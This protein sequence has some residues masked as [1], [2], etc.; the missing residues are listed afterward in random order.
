MEAWKAGG[1][2][3]KAERQKEWKVKFEIHFCGL[4]VGKQGQKKGKTSCDF[5]IREIHSIIHVRQRILCVGGRGMHNVCLCVLCVYIHTHKHYAYVRVCVSPR[6]YVLIDMCVCVCVC[7]CTVC[8]YLWE[9][10]GFRPCP[11][12]AQGLR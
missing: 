9:G 3:E 10:E 5:H 6:A 12:S 4:Q 7:I 2:A 1:K 8:I 11:G